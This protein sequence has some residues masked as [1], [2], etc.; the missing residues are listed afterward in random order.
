VKEKKY[1]IDLYSAL[2]LSSNAV[3]YADVVEDDDKVTPVV[4]VTNGW[5]DAARRDTI[6]RNKP[7]ARR[8]GRT[9]E[10]KQP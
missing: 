5:V 8:D 10:V 1:I 7:V 6:T 4:G 9:V 2:L 3:A